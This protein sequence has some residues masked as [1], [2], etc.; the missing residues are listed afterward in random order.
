[1]SIGVL[2]QHEGVVALHGT[3]LEARMY[4]QPGRRIAQ[5][6]SPGF[7]VCMHE[8]FASL[9]YGSTLVLRKDDNDPFSHLPDVDVAAINAS[10]ASSL[11]PSEY[12]NLKYV[13]STVTSY[14]FVTYGCQNR[15]ISQGNQSPRKQQ[16]NGLLVDNCSI[17]MVPPRY[18]IPTW[19]PNQLSLRRSIARCCW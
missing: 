5:F 7:D 10:V 13:S 2:C 11:D 16:T 8:I 12:A 15:S 3:S 17:P 9:C 1:M 18:A 4:S 19:C 14:G 6:L